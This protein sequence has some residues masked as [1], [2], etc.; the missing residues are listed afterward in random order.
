MQRRAVLNGVTALAA[1]TTLTALPSARADDAPA[2][3]PVP[4][5]DWFV[6]LERGAPTPPDKERVSA[7]QKGHIAN[8]GRLFAAGKLFAAGP[9]RDP[10]Q[11]KRG[12]VV[13]RAP[14]LDTLRR[15]FDEDE[16]VALGH[17]TLN[18]QP[19]V[20]KKALNTTGLNLQK[21]VEN[22]IVML[23]RT[24][25]FDQAPARQLPD[26]LGVLVE[27]GVFGAW[28]EMEAGPIHHILFRKGTDDA[29][30]HEALE[31]LPGRTVGGLQ[32]DVWSQW[33]AEGVVR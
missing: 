31:S 2:P 21:I 9:M 25:S 3:V 26:R 33:F 20:V 24:G 29:P 10:T 13:V 4:G 27:S 15:Y 12:I 8:F 11:L 32:A 28:Y 23:T 19:C 1:L 7:M 22:R 14:D 5:R 18:A 6:F 17:M 16:Y 30:L